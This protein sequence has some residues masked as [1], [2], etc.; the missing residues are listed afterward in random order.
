MSYDETQDQA[1]QPTGGGIDDQSPHDEANVDFDPAF[2]SEGKK[3]LNRSVVMF[4]GLVVL[5]ALVI[6]FMYFRGG[7]Q[8]AQGG[9]NAADAGAQIRSFLGS[10]NIQ[11]MKQTL[12]ETE[13]IVNQFRHND[14][15]KTQIPLVALRSNPFRELP[16]KTDDPGPVRS[17][18]DER[19]EEAHKQILNAV[20]E[21]HLQSIIHGGKYRACMINNTLYKEGQQIGILK[22][23]QVTAANVVVSGGKYRF[24]LKMQK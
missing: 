17:G 12:R 5:G 3:P 23:E 15:T 4:G 7:P 11:M 20:G 14:P 10:D 19:E 16:P 18:D 6:W 2:V 8:A 1:Q 9:T 13:K 21:L 24:E 22:I